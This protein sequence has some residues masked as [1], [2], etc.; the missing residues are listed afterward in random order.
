MITN[1]KREF[2]TLLVTCLLIMTC[3]EAHPYNLGSRLNV[4]RTIHRLA[5]ES[6]RLP[7]RP[8]SWTSIRWSDDYVSRGGHTGASIVQRF[9]R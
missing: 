9:A 3:L 5:V 6:P 4:S 2:F 1:E 8:H 7:L